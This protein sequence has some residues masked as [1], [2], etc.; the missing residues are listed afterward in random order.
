MVR[1]IRNIRGKG[2]QHTHNSRSEK[3]I[4]MIWITG[5]DTYFPR[6]EFIDKGTVHVLREGF[7]QPTFY[8]GRKG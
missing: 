2:N 7:D 5:R 8:V 6:K 1:R 4:V 3:N